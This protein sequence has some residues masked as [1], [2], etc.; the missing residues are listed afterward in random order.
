MREKREVKKKT[1]ILFWDRILSSSPGWPKKYCVAYLD[2][3]WTLSSPPASSFQML[4][5]Q[6]C[7]LTVLDWKYICYIFISC[8]ILFISATF[9]YKYNAASNNTL[10][11]GV[12]I[13][14]MLWHLFGRAKRLPFCTGCWGRSSLTGK[15][16]GKQHSSRLSQGS[17]VAACQEC[18]KNTQRSVW[19]E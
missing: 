12:N 5:L 13:F 4:G 18:S 1:M 17:E 10:A 19:L 3:F 9:F 11:V 14:W 8:H 15:G 6:A 16:G 2:W 7:V